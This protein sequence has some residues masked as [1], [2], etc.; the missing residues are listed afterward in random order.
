MGG[1]FST[2]G[3]GGGGVENKVICY[4]RRGLGVWFLPSRMRVAVLGYREL[5]GE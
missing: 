3:L 4:V 1:G 2:V 5:T